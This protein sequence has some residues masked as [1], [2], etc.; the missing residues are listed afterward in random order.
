MRFY[1]DGDSFTFGGGLDRVFNIDPTKYRWSKIVSDYFGAEEINLSQC[2]CSNDRV[3]RQF[4]AEGRNFDEYDFIFIQLTCAFRS[5]F[6][7]DEYN[8]WVTY[9]LPIEK[10][11]RFDK[12]RTVKQRVNILEKESKRFGKEYHE[13]KT[14]RAANILSDTGAMVNEL[15]AYNSIKSHLELI[16][17][18]FFISALTNYNHINYD[19][20]FYKENYDRIAYDG[21]PSILGHKQIARRII[22]KIEDKL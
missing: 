11:K 4:F 5:E 15:V 16:E 1:F 7:S 18:P 22:H 20:N 2:G 10:N 13:W 21:H 14:Y 19:F 6:W 9:S 12:D 8:K 17:K 3:L